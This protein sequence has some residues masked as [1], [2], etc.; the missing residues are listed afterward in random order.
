MNENIFDL[1]NQVT[2]SERGRMCSY[3]SDPTLSFW[4]LFLSS[5][6]DGT[7]YMFSYSIFLHADLL[8]FLRNKK[9][10][11][12]GNAETFYRTPPRK[13]ILCVP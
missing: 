11:N 5:K 1:T 2:I 13:Y 9:M 10:F 6:F 3:S 7:I 8:L 4:L 12:P